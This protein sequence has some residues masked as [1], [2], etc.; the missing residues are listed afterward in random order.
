A[1]DCNYNTTCKCPTGLAERQ[2]CGGEIGIL[3]AATIHTSMNVTLMAI[4]VIIVIVTVAT[5]A[6]PY[7][8]PNPPQ[9]TIMANSSQISSMGR[10]TSSKYETP[11]PTTTTTDTP[12][13]N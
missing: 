13:D 2:H 10:T 9:S 6:G 5:S 8:I 4:L 7:S 1:A 3:F 12:S 11:T